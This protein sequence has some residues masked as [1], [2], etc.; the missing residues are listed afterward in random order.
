MRKLFLNFIFLSSFT[1]FSQTISEKW[2]SIYNRYDYTDSGGNLVGY[3]GYNSLTQSWEY[4]SVNE[5]NTRTNQYNEY[6]APMDLQM[7]DRTLAIKQARYDKLKFQENSSVKKVKTYE[8]VPLNRFSKFIGGYVS[9][10]LIEETYDPKT[11]KY[12]QTFKDHIDT[13]MYFDYGIMYFYYPDAGKWGYNELELKSDIGN[14]YIFRDEK[15]EQTIMITKLFDSITVHRYM[16][17]GIFQKVYRFNLLEKD[18]SIK[19]T[20]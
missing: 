16:K 10:L 7:L 11:K 14:F 3:K 19:L 9:K 18:N 8:E 15:F 1:C 6:Q 20:N 12:K 5:P 2:N 17:D 13:K 4:T